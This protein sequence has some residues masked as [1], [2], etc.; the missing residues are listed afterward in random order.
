MMRLPVDSSDRRMKGGGLMGQGDWI[1][2]S[3][4]PVPNRVLNRAELCPSAVEEREADP[5][6][7]PMGNVRPIPDDIRQRMIRL[8]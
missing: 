2:T 4:L 3:D 5:K 1:R 7:T 8:I 6:D